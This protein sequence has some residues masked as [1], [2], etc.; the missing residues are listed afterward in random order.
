L[1]LLLLAALQRGELKVVDG[2]ADVVSRGTAELGDEGAVAHV[3][4]LLLAHL[5]QALDQPYILRGCW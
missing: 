4:A 3:Q 1:L 2:R 5:A